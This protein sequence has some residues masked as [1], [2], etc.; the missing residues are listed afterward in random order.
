MELLLTAFL[1][2]ILGVWIYRSI[3]S[4]S[5]LAQ[6]PILRISSTNVRRGKVSI[7]IPAKNE[8]KNIADCVQ[9]LLAQL[10][11]GD[12]LLVI[13]NCSADR[14]ETILKELGAV[15]ISAAGTPPQLKTAPSFR[16]LNTPQTP[17]GW[18]GKNFALHLGIDHASCDWIL[19]TDADTRHAPGS[20]D[21]SVA[22]AE[23]NKVDLLTLLPRALAHG[24]WENLIQPCAMGYMGLWFPVA[25]INDPASKVHF[26][27]GQYLLIRKEHY[28]KLGGHAAVRE[29]FLEDFALMKK[30]KEMN[31]RGICAFGMEIYGTRMYDS[32]GALWRGWRRIYLHAFEQAPWRILKCVLSVFFFSVLP[33]LLLGAA[34]HGIEIL[35]GLI[36]MAIILTT[37]IKAATIVKIRKRYALLHPLAALVFLG[38]LAD[39]L[40]MALL[41]RPTLW[42]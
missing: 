20:I 33:L 19:F 38:I 7:L 39:A 32:F 9:P 10:H 16:Y 25:K 28:Q 22:F 5:E 2:W 6:A 41:K 29:A 18:T 17:N 13:N 11:A 31:A 8:E 42:R 12:E 4:L 24:F 23:K 40:H 37:A 34:P 36:I 1:V 3:R 27:N 15:E 26:G 30:T 21:A 35:L 14:T